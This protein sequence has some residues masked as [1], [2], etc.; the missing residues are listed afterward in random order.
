VNEG[1]NTIRF[2]NTMLHLGLG[3]AHER[4]DVIAPIKNDH[5]I[6]IDTHGTVLGEYKLDPKH[7]YQHKIKTRESPFPGVHVSTMS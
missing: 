1:K 2:G 4:T 7:R 5:A 3:R 6:V